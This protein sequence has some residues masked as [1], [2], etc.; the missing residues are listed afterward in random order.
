MKTA[1]S[2]IADTAKL[3]AHRPPARPRFRQDCTN[4]N[5]R[6]FQRN[7]T[8]PNSTQP[9]VKK[10]LTAIRAAQKPVEKRPNCAQTGV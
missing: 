8:P 1:F 4:F 9:I 7:Q 5:L 6:C 2:N 10:R 3:P